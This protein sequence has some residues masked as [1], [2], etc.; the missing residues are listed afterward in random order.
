LGLPSDQEAEEFLQRQ[1]GRLPPGIAERV[2]RLRHAPFLARTL[3]GLLLVCGGL[4]WFLP[5]L[6]FWMLPLGLILLADQFRITKRL[7]AGASLY[8][9]RR[10]HR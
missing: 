5:I 10:R 2:V 6:G 1:L 3:V 8:F 4:A 9:A 7:L